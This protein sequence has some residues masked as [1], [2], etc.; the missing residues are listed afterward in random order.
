MAYLAPL[1]RSLLPLL[2]SV[3]LAACSTDGLMIDSSARVSAIEPQPQRRALP[4][5]ESQ[6]TY[7]APV[8]VATQAA[9]YPQAG[10]AA[11]PP[12]ALPPIDS[13]EAL[14]LNGSTPSGG[15]QLGEPPR[16]L[17]QLTMNQGGQLVA[18][19]AM[20]PAPA[21]QV[22]MA[23]PSDPNQQGVSIDDGLGVG[24]GATSLAQEEAMQIAETNPSEPVV[25]GIGTDNPVAYPSAQP[26]DPLLAEQAGYPE[27]APAPPRQSYPASQQVAML[28]RPID[29]TVNPV[30]PPRPAAM[31]NSE[32][33]CRSALQK[34]G[35]KFQDVP[36]ISNGRACGIAYP[37]KVYG[38]ASNIQ[39]KPAITLNCQVTYAFAQWVKNELNPSARYRYW[40]GVKT[41]IPLG[42]Y[43]CRR[44]NSSARN[45]W[46]E[47]ARGNAID[48]G[49][50]ILNNGKEIDVRKPG[51]FS[52]R[53]KGLLNAVRSESCKYFHT[54]LGPGSDPHHKDHFHF[55]LRARKSGYR[56]CD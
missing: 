2:I 19:Q 5:A 51:F 7:A 56:H 53:E 42:G 32:I 34:L 26:A 41:I 36:A 44:M 29:P 18:P 17:G 10:L 24:G 50:F 35:V 16:V 4:V 14:A 38:F 11:Q 39:M 6:Q 46:S 45:P 9:A 47:H 40:S 8:P 13:D 49:K 37:I 52:F 48:V 25:G 1:R 30:L 15:P 28:P 21:Q 3:S 43:S 12:R 31:P 22:A 33:A 20:Q 55:D 27:T 54:V 23:D